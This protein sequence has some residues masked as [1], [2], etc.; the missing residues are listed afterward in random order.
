MELHFLGGASEVGRSAILFKGSKHIIMD[1]GI[2]LNHKTEYPLPTGGVDAC[3]LSHAHIDHSGNFPFLYKDNLPTTYGT[4]PTKELSQLLVE[5]SMKVGKKNH[6]P[7]K[8]NKHNLRSM[9]ERYSSHEFG[10][11]V[12]LGEYTITLYDAGHISGSSITKIESRKT[13][14]RL[15]Y[16]G[17]F[18]LEPQMIQGSADIVKSDVLITETT[19]A[20]REHPEREELT[21]KFAEDVRQTL[22][23]GGTALIPTFA[24]GRAQEI[25]AI[26]HKHGLTDSVFIDGMA[27]KATQIAMRYP[28]YI[29]NVDLLHDAI[30]R[31]AWVGSEEHR[32]HAISGSSIILTTA[33]M[34]NGGPVL[35]YI[36][37]LGPNSKIFLTGYQ[38]EGTNGRKLM[39]GKPLLI[40]GRKEVVKA[41]WTFYDFSAHAGKSDLYEYVRKS[42]PEKVICVHGEQKTASAFA[43]S[44]REEG[45]DASVPKQGDTVQIDL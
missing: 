25:L 3:V 41:P 19:Y 39:D 18:K 9:L 27:R 36:T 7:P 4:D 13:G 44:L 45:Y 17:D 34:L 38:V 30:K 15:V 6:Q 14:K 28:E 23:N 12:D 35:N 5:D 20:N 11:E 16:T 8:F 24:V 10:E 42:D 2:K 26:L 43:E 22:D 1:Y 33:G 37:K 21:K 40:D 29:R 31:I 32:G